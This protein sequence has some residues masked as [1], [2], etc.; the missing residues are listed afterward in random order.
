MIDRVVLFVAP[1]WAAG[2]GLPL[3]DGRAPGL[4]ALDGAR[5][6][7]VGA[8]IRIDIDVHRSH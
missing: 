3:F 5:V 6:A 8:D 1:L 2:D 7:P 4:S